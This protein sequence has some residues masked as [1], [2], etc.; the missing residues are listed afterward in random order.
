MWTAVSQLGLVRLFK[1]PETTLL[2]SFAVA[3]LL[4]AFLLWLPSSHVDAPITFVDALFTSTSAVC[5]TG[6]TVVDTG[7]VFSRF[8][9][10]V[11]VALIQMGGLGIMTLAA[12]ASLVSGHRM[13]M[14]SQAVVSD[15]FFQRDA[16]AE[17]LSTLRT[18]LV[19]T[20]AIECAGALVLFAD[21]MLRDVPVASAAFS[22]VFHSVSAFCNAGFSIY[23]DN[24]IEVRDSSP[25]L[26][27]IMA[28][29]VLGGLGYV[30][31]NEIWTFFT[32]RLPS[33]HTAP[34]PRFSLNSRVVLRVTPLLIV[35]G[36]LFIMGFG[37][38]AQETSLYDMLMQ[39]LFQSV[40]ARTAGFNTVDCGK[41]PS[42]SL[43]VLIMLMFI[44]GSPASCAGG[45]KTTTFAVW[46]ARLRASL[47]GRKE[48]RLLDRSIPQ[49]QLNRVDLLLGLAVFWNILG[50]MVLFNTEGRMNFAALDLIFEQV[51][52]FGT[53][54][55]STG[56]TPNLSTPGKLWLCAT[57]Y[58]GRLGPLTVAL[59]MFS[60]TKVN[61]RYPKGTVMIG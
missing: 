52:A 10:V 24:L 15:T 1:A 28:L 11:I 61:V 29:I 26:L 41:L 19:L 12:L 20:A 16:G 45:V 59:W 42:A 23:R 49:D 40:T 37:L 60:K 3:I 56:V 54:G 30:V 2:G 9:Q 39:S 8:G 7:T 17:F 35:G 6:L 50:I 18:I 22:A 38:T 4:G 58:V 51:S 43:F 31:L 53:V 34:G 13:S 46:L 55:L 14:Q 44:G 25:F 32:G 48:V 47:K 36:T 57:M 27:V 5:V 33:R 21:L